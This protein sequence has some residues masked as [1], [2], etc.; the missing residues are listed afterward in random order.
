MNAQQVEAIWNQYRPRVEKIF[1]DAAESIRAQGGKADTT[2]YM[3]MTD[4][5]FG[6]AMDCHKPDGTRFAV[7]FYLAEEQYR[8]GIN[9]GQQ[10][11][12]APAITVVENFGEILGGA[13]PYNYT[14]KLWAHSA[15]EFEHRFELLEDM[16]WNINLV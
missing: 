7:N 10:N 15:Q 6:L 5:E 3:D 14:H 11:G 12:L 8:E 2:D 1:V 9:P 16:D 13:T 4:E